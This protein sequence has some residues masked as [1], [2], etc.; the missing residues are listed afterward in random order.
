MEATAAPKPT[1]QCEL[2][3]KKGGFRLG[4]PYQR[5]KQLSIVESEGYLLMTKHHARVSKVVLL[6][7][8]ACVSLSTIAD[9]QTRAGRSSF[10]RPLAESF[11]SDTPQDT[12]LL[13]A[14]YTGD[15]DQ[16]TQLLRNGANVNA[17]QQNPHFNHGWTPICFGVIQSNLAM[18]RLLL[19]YHADVRTC[20]LPVGTVRNPE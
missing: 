12:S 8:I 4:G 3:E 16:L 1:G 9:S 13:L 6:I 5:E 17:Q 15:M 7:A 19:R 14:A 20:G 18:V 2:R 11:S 10:T